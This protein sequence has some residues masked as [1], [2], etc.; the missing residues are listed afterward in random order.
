MTEQEENPSWSTIIFVIGFIVVSIPLIVYAYA[1]LFQ[2][3][4]F[5]FSIGIFVGCGTFF[6][7]KKEG[8]KL[9]D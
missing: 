8:V 5:F 1:W 2:R 7:D 3:S 4:L 9:R 6:I